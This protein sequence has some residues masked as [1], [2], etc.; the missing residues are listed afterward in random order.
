MKNTKVNTFEMGELVRIIES[1]HCQ[2]RLNGAVGTISDLPDKPRKGRT[3]RRGEN[4]YAVT[5]SPPYMDKHGEVN[6]MSF[7][8]WEL[9]PTQG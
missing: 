2:H 1:P 7:H 6:V 3:S 4:G 8:D 9:E 5:F